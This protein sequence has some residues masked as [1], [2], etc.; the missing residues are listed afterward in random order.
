MDQLGARW[1]IAH[2][3]EA[4]IAGADHLAAGDSGV[5]VVDGSLERPSAPRRAQAREPADALV[6]EDLDL[7]APRPGAQ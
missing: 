3:V 2:D 1:V 4:N 6:I 5:D 7:L